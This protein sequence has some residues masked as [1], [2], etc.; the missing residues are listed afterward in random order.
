MMRDRGMQTLQGAKQ[1]GIDRQVQTGKELIKGYKAN[2]PDRR[3]LGE[4]LLDQVAREEYF[5]TLELFDSFTLILAQ[6]DNDL[7]LNKL[8][9]QL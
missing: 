7:L 5:K 6:I 2:E 9:H 1:Y 3:P 8:N 4:G